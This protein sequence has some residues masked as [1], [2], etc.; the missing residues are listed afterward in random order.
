MDN[1]E[2]SQRTRPPLLGRERELAELEAA[3][4]DA[5]AGR[6]G[7]VLVAGESGIGKTR[8]AETVVDRA[9]TAGALVLW[10]RCWDSGGGSAFWPWVQAIRR[11]LDESD[12]QELEQLLGAGAGLVA[13]I[14]PELRERLPDAPAYGSLES[15]QARF[16]LFDGVA[17]LLRRAARERPLVVVLDDLHSADQASLL[18]LEFFAQAIAGDPILVLGTYQEAA[19][20]QRPEV[21]RLLGTLARDTSPVRLGGLDERQLA[22]LIEQRAGRPAPAELVGA[23]LATTDG[24]PFFAD[25]LVRLL[26]ARDDVELWAGGTL[27]ARFPLPDSVRE[28]VRR[29]FDSLGEEGLTT[30]QTAAVI[31]REFRVGTLERATGVERERLLELLDEAARAGL[32]VEQPGALGGFRFSHG[33]I[34]DTLYSELST[35][36]RVRLHRTVGEALEHVHGAVPD[37]LAEL[38]YHF[39]EAAPGGDADRALELAIAAGR[40]AMDVL[41]FEHAAELFELALR[42][43]ELV[44]PQPER[45]AELVLAVG[46]ARARA[47]DE[48]ARPTLIEAAAAARA[49]GRADLLARAALGIRSF[50]FGPGVPD[51]VLLPMFDEALDRLGPGDDALRARLLARNSV[52]LYYSAGSEQRRAAL[53]EEAVKLARE[54]GDR[55]TLA[56]VL[57]NVQLG[58]WGPDTVEQCLAWT[59]ELLGL[60]QELGDAELAMVARHRQ[61]DFLL[62]L[63]DLA[64]ADI[65]LEALVRVAAESPD[66]RAQAYVLLHRA[67]RELLEG[68]F[69]EAERLNAEAA[70]EGERLRDPTIPVLAAAQRFGLSWTLERHGELETSIRRY[71]DA[72]PG[73]PAWRVGLAIVYCKL[74]RE[75]PARREFDRLAAD[76]FVAVPRDND[77]LLNL[78]LLTEVCATLG[79]AE[80]AATLYG[81]LAPFEQR[82]AVCPHAFVVGPVTRFLGKLA[83]TRGDVGAATGH[84]AA[85][86]ASA[87]ALNSPPLLAQVEADQAQVGAPPQAAT[88]AEGG[89]ATLRREGDVWA[90]A[91]EDRLVRVRD[92]KGVGYLATLLANPGVEVHATDLAAGPANRAETQAGAAAELDGDAGQDAGPVL[93]ASAKAAYRGR[94]EELRE[95]LEEAEAFNDPERAAR[96]R[97]EL[98][99]I[100]GELA[101]AVGLGGRD[102]KLGSTAER[103]RVNV[104]RAI[105]G[106]LKRVEEHDAAL[107]AELA[108]TVRTG[109]FCAFE[110][111]PRRPVTWRVEDG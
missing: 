90:F 84:F 34:R 58:L 87:A 85:A 111:D 45:Q 110:P 25:E 33:L 79:D 40:Y 44:D 36:T 20:R 73:M 23:L 48:R 72:A 88:P 57:S 19:A 29:H 10:G 78:G 31:G 1:A 12:A 4:G 81:L 102:R 61:I 3:L 82:L 104:T 93:D 105:R 101:G 27:R 62:E 49:V 43:S 53:A 35:A 80:R 107:G 5:R 91:W 71:A 28:A 24:N 13:Q 52:A 14:V 55:A 66:P 100:A 37:R 96:A 56:F 60:T 42:V 99:L 97:E 30:L 64:G 21:E 74:G 26:V 106:V 51:D 83:A 95:E 18:L 50:A 103:A 63:D 54:L 75:A 7:V 46:E 86:A 2:T 41:A 39:A 69:G 108:T 98:D 65:A 92:S 11:L 70:A 47:D 17:S 77:F 8:L 9:E 38:A 67:R 89:S 16:A 68:R 32:V 6:G 22:E 109:T 76:G 59:E 94:L 15:E